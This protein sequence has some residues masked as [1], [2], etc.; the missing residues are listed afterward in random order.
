M[1][2]CRRIELS[3]GALLLSAPRL[4]IDQNRPFELYCPKAACREIYTPRSSRPDVARLEQF[5]Y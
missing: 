1:A 4:F 5:D 2:M 3:C